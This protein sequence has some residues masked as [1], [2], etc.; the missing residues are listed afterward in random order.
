MIDLKENFFLLVIEE[1][2]LFDLLLWFIILEVF[3]K[4]FFV[5]YIIIINEYILCDIYIFIFIWNIIF[6]IL[7]NVLYWKICCFSIY[8]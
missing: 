2:Y 6:K 5:W 7:I 4:Y 8:C 1:D 3:F